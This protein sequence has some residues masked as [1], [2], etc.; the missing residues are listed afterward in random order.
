M[1]GKKKL[2]V[3]QKQ[4]WIEKGNYVIRVVSWKHPVFREAVQVYIYE[5]LCCKSSQCSLDN[6]SA[7][8]ECK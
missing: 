2:V 5:L 4:T 3:L 6:T 1:T 8:D 7:K